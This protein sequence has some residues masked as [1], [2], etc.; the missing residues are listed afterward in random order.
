MKKPKKNKKNTRVRSIL[1]AAQLV[2]ELK[3]LKTG[4][5][6]YGCKMAQDIFKVKIIPPDPAT[7]IPSEVIKAYLQ[8]LWQRIDRKAE[9]ITD[10]HSE[11]EN[12]GHSEGY[13]YG[14]SKSF[15]ECADDEESKL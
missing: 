12:C 5:A 15:I 3:N 1:S 4:E 6:I 10:S 7:E 2:K 9:S 13:Y 8:Q 14:T 11:I